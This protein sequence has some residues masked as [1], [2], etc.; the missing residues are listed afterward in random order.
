VATFT[1]LV[2]EELENYDKQL[3]LF[4]AGGQSPPHWYLGLD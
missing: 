2:T 4:D 1:V 3:M